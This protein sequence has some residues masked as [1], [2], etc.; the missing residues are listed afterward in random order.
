MQH[1]GLVDKTPQ[2]RVR[3]VLG[4][5]VVFREWTSGGHFAA[6]LFF[7][8][9]STSSS[10]SPPPT[11]HHQLLA[12]CAVSTISD[13]EHPSDLTTLHHQHLLLRAT[14]VSTRS[15]TSCAVL[16]NSRLSRHAPPSPPMFKDLASAVMIQ[17]PTLAMGATM[18]VRLSRTLMVQA[19]AR[20]FTVGSVALPQRI[21]R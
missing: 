9:L 3:G 6:M 12:F 1:I 7:F 15:S 5:R 8:A 11:F 14:C 20:T 4:Q 17:S 19:S 2:R 10:S 18:R 16:E 21:E 13:A